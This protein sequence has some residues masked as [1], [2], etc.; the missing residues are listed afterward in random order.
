MKIKERCVCGALFE[1]SDP[2]GTFIT[3]GCHPDENG[4]QYI[5][6]RAL[7]EFRAVHLP[8]LEKVQGRER[9]SGERGD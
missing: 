9:P 7:R 5:I 2:K 8:C 6:E 4:D 3:S 1:G